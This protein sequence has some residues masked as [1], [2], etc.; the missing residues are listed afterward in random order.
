MISWEEEEEEEEEE[1]AEEDAAARISHIVKLRSA[2]S[3]A[4]RPLSPLHYYI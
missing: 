4:A 3:C 1:D 2:F